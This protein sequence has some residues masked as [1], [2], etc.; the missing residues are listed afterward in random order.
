MRF[1]F[2]KILFAS[3]LCLT[4]AKAAYSQLNEYD[5]RE[6]GVSFQLPNGWR[7][8]GPDRWGEQQSTL[9]LREPATR[10][11]VMLYVQILGTPEIISA[12]AMNRKLLR[13][14]KYKVRQRIREGHADYHLR[15]NS[16]ELRSINGRSALSWVAEFTDHGQSMVEYLTR[17][18]SESTNA[19]FY[20]KLPAQHLEDFKGRLDPIIE[21]LQIP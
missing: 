2:A 3:L 9:T 5:D 19:L 17:V 7:W 6:D 8:A 21:T 15:E 10:Q 1:L 16:C 12:E 13:G 14:V 18:R 20:V 11:E 4:A